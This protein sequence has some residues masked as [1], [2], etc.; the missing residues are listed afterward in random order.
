M[1]RLPRYRLALL[2]WI[3]TLCCVGLT[4]YREVQS[5]RDAQA[6]VSGRYQNLLT[7]VRVSGDAV[8]YGLFNDW[9]YWKGTAYAGAADLPQGYWVYVWP[10]WYVWEQK[11]DSGI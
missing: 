9:G 1:K 4:L 8:E 3:V 7:K 10:E 11:V 2:L 6:T 5:W